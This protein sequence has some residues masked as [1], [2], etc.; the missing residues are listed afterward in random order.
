LSIAWRSKQPD[1][2]VGARHLRL[3]EQADL[4]EI[5]GVIDSATK[6]PIASWKPSL[7]PLR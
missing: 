1:V 5:I 7:A 4:N 3:V 2:L 6:S